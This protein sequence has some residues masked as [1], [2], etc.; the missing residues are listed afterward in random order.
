MFLFLWS[1]ALF[2]LWGAFYAWMTTTRSCHRCF[3]WNLY[4]AYSL[5]AMLSHLFSLWVRLLL[6]VCMSAW[7]FLWFSGTYSFLKILD[8]LCKSS[9]NLR[10]SWFRLAVDSCYVSNGFTGM[11]IGEDSGISIGLGLWF[12]WFWLGWLVFSPLVWAGFCVFEI[13]LKHFL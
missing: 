2:S 7:L 11:A 5:W 13:F 12:G 8:D 4:L 6:L 10:L 3:Q 9:L 1:R